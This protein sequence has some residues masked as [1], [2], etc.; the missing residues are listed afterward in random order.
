MEQFAVVLVT[1]F[2]RLAVT[3]SS[4]YMKFGTQVTNAIA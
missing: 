1:A 4:G 3:V 2:Q